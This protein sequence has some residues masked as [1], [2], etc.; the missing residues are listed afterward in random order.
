MC[1]SLTI[2]RVFFFVYVGKNGYT[3]YSGVTG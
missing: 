1:S 3:K 2:V